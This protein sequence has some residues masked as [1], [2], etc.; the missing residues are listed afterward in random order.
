M[1]DPNQSYVGHSGPITLQ[2]ILSPM[3]PPYP[4]KS[5]QTV[6]DMVPGFIFKWGLPGCSTPVIALTVASC[7]HMRQ[8]SEVAR[9]FDKDAHEK[10]G[11]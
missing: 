9:T 2:G 11:M 7:F 5:S 1:S 3:T 10:G 6:V 4:I 8:L